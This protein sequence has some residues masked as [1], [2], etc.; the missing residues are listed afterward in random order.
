M[1]NYRFYFTRYDYNRHPQRCS[2]SLE[3]WVHELLYFMFLWGGWRGGGVVAAKGIVELKR[4]KKTQ[5]GFI[6]VTQ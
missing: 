1:A 3:T 5:L 4:E 6:G 2:F